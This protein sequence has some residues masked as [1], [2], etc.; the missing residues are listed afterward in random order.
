VSYSALPKNVAEAYKAY[1]QQPNLKVC[2]SV[3]STVNVKY[4]SVHAEAT[5]HQYWKYG[6]YFNINGK[7][8]YLNFSPVKD[9]PFA[10]DNT[11]IYWPAKLNVSVEEYLQVDYCRIKWKTE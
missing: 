5:A 10:I 11:Y 1:G 6:Y 7:K 3:D 4:F 8:V 2:F 9:S